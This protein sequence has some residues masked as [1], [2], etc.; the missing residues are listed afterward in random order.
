MMDN[1]KLVPDWIAKGL[2]SNM[3]TVK[4]LDLTPVF[5]T[6]A[7]VDHHD[8][9]N[10]GDVEEHYSRVFHRDYPGRIVAIFYGPNHRADSESYCEMCQARD[11]Q[12]TT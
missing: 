9:G 12:V 5:A 11:G 3:K 7:H 6:P 10:E 1:P 4:S 2:I 8:Y